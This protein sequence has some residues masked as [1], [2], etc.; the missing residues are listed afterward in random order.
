MNGNFSRRIIARTIAAK[1]AAEP[2]RSEHWMKV[3]AAY[4][5]E[6]KQADLAELIANDIAREVFKQ[7]GELLVEVTSAYKM[8]ET[9]RKDLQNA[10]TAA[11]GAKDVT[12]SEQV[13]PELIGGLVA[14]TPD[15]ILDVSVRSQLKQLAAIN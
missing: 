14:Q 15:A 2:S 7:R 4:L 13:D 10:L 8:S 9:V 5:L 6:H 3:L 11:T 1:L 12:F